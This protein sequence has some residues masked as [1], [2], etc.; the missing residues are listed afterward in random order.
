MK[1]LSIRN[2]WISLG[3]VMVPAAV[4]MFLLRHSQEGREVVQLLM[5]VVSVLILHVL[6][7]RELRRKG[8][9]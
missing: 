1:D 7:R 6:D 9:S 2:I 4:A 3:L 5:V 8:E